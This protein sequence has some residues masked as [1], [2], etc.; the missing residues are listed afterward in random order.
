M[1]SP[2]WGYHFEW[3]L[4]QLVRVTTEMGFEAP[5]HDI[6]LWEDD[7]GL[8]CADWDAAHCLN[9]GD[10]DFP[11]Q[12]GF[13]M[14]ANEACCV[15]QDVQE[16][17]EEDI[18]I[19]A[20]EGQVCGCDGFV[21][22]GTHSEA[23]NAEFTEWVEVDGHVDCDNDFFEDDPSPWNA[24]YCECMGEETGYWSW[25]WDGE[26]YEFGWYGWNDHSWIWANWGWHD[27]GW[28]WAGWY[29]T[30]FWGWHFEWGWWHA[31][32]INP[33][34]DAG[35]A[36]IYDGAHWE[37]GQHA[38]GATGTSAYIHW[39]GWKW[40]ENWGWHLENGLWM[41]VC[42]SCEEPDGT[43]AW[44]WMWDGEVWEL[45]Y[46]AWWGSSWSAW[47]W[48]GW[49]WSEEWGWHLENGWWHLV[50]MYT[51]DSEE[52]YELFGAEYEYIGCFV[53]EDGS[54][55][56]GSSSTAST[57]DECASN[58][59]AEGYQ[60][61]G[62]QASNECYC[63]NSYGS[64]GESYNCDE[65]C[66]G[67]SD[68]ICGGD[69]SNSVYEI[70]A[71]GLY[72]DAHVCAGEDEICQCTGR[73]RYGNYETWTDW[74]D[75]EGEIECSNDSFEDPLPGVYKY[76]E[77]ALHEDHTCTTVFI[78]ASE[79]NVATVET[80]YEYAYCRNEAVNEQMPYWGDT[81]DVYVDG[82]EVTVQRTDNE[83][84]WGQSLEI[85]CCT[86][87]LTV[88]LI[89]SGSSS[90]DIAVTDAT[91]YDLTGFQFDVTADG[92]VASVS[93]ASTDLDG[94]DVQGSTNTGT[95]IGYS[96]SL[97]TIACGEETC[98]VATATLDVDASAEICVTNIVFVDTDLETIP[99]TLDSCITLC[100]AGSG[101]IDGD[102]DLNVLD[103]VS[104]VN[105]ILYPELDQDSC[106]YLTI[107][108]DGDGSV[109]VVDIVMFVNIILYP[110]A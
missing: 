40:S 46:H 55:L 74:V 12:P 2:V 24:K 34:F 18:F 97:D 50:Y 44:V 79:E 45:D 35:W 65:P 4:S 90:V 9:H 25:Q 68:I 99:A 67:D 20:Y 72:A 75:V 105:E 85:L 6:G 82:T 57:P 43:W 23:G 51:T 86:Q 110:D 70:T 102:G 78:G 31:V 3:G 81:Y 53:D 106:E 38:W 56:G 88:T 69:S 59:A 8:T 33:N 52:G 21:R 84:G 22:Y 66:E 54:D 28:N 5:C 96:M 63:G 1:W 48:Y 11:G 27:A 49:K 76:C 91:P 32:W 109:N 42:T 94:F 19:C 77:C 73:V 93:D 13:P 29:W 80:A 108:A 17:L 103:I 71:S 14:T 37:T 98:V 104:I 60:Y 47:H 89:S 95:V 16:S 100:A 87:Q 62:T 64:F 30:E 15:C 58:C 26:Y 41:W 61:F 83:N 92:S 10:E 36:L 101:D 39:M 7:A 107:D